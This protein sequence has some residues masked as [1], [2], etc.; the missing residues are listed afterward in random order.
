V[1][2]Y[3]HLSFSHYSTCC[4]DTHISLYAFHIS[5]DIFR[6]FNARPRKTLSKGWNVLAG[7]ERHRHLS[8]HSFNLLT[9]ECKVSLRLRAVDLLRINSVYFV[10]KYHPPMITLKLLDYTCP[11][12]RSSQIF[13]NIPLLLSRYRLFD[14]FVCAFH[15]RDQPILWLRIRCLVLPECQNYRIF[16]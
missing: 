6:K 15:L 14:F 3:R 13:I 11:L 9:H 8:T 10:I 4:C 5:K 16:L 7:V 1:G 12:C 2:E